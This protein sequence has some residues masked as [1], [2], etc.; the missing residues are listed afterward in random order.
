V[1]RIIIFGPFFTGSTHFDSPKDEVFAVPTFIFLKISKKNHVTHLCSQFYM[2]CRGGT[3]S[4]NSCFE[5]K[6]KTLP[7]LLVSTMVGH[8]HF[9]KLNGGLLLLVKLSGTLLL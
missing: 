2:Y 6:S 5:K 7:I 8:D 1:K 9:V 4:K 3:F